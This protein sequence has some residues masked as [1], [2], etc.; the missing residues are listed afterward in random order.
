MQH[1]STRATRMSRFLIGALAVCALTGSASAAHAAPLATG[2]AAATAHL[3]VIPN[4]PGTVKPKGLAE[5]AGTANEGF[6]DVAKSCPYDFQP[7]QPVTLTATADAG[8]DFVGW[9]DERCPPTDTCTLPMDAVAQSVTAN[10]SPQRLL[11]KTA[12]DPNATTTPQVTAAGRDCV[13]ASGLPVG[14]MDCG[15][16][17]LL[18]R[19]E[20]VASPATG[21]TFDG[22]LCDPPEP[23]PTA[24][25]NCTVLINKPTWASVGFGVDP[26]DLDSDVVPP[27]ISVNFRVIKQGS[28]SG[29]VSGSLICGNACGPVT[30][31]FGTRVTLSADP[32]QGSTFSGWRGACGSAPNCS[33]AVG[34]VTTLVAVFNAAGSSAGSSGSSSGSSGSSGGSSGS[35]SSGS[36]TSHSTPFVAQLRRFVVSGHGRKR[37]ILIRV[38]ANAPATCQATLTS[39]RGHRVTSKRWRV[40]AGSP[41]LRLK[42]PARTRRGTYKLALSLSD[43]KGHVTRVSRR[44]PIPR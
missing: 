2:L 34:P 38:Q 13:P 36:G 24:V 15:A 40:A 31:D 22:R 12:T 42:V 6:N 41:L 9:S 20:L 7:G 26:P 17:P 23:L 30:K 1:Q 14:N 27:A 3:D 44:V 28:G 29:T 35:S 32:A 5:C 21:T 43:G 25:T 10:F 18:S 33:L 37:K 4:G 39:R 16:F 11:I 19:V 8:F